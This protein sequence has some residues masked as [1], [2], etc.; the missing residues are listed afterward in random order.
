LAAW[1]CPSRFGPAPRVKDSLPPGVFWDFL[2]FSSSSLPL[3]LLRFSSRDAQSQPHSLPSRP[4]AGDAGTARS[5]AS[6]SPQ[7][8]AGIADGTDAARG[9]TRR[10]FEVEDQGG[11]G[12][13]PPR[14]PRLQPRPRF[15]PRAPRAEV[16][17]RTD[18]AEVAPPRAPVHVTEPGAAA[19]SRLVA[20]SP[21]RHHM[22]RSRNLEAKRKRTVSVTF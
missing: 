3:S 2:R 22:G 10:G 15:V 4:A 12:R 16:P 21:P 5:W 7:S 6:P 11:G 8:T 13:N 19:S 18:C 20:F 17:G 9:A 14:L 1:A